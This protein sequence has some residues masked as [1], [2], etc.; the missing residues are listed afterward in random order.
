[1]KKDKVVSM[2]VSENFSEALGLLGG[3]G[4]ISTAIRSAVLAYAKE[5]LAAIESTLSLTQSGPSNSIVSDMAEEAERLRA[6]IRLIES[7]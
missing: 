1:M 7:D 4:A 3:L 5:R 6:A 2:R